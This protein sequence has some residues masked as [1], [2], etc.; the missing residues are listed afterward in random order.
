MR[1]CKQCVHARRACD[2]KE[3]KCS[4]KGKSGRGDAIACCAFKLSAR[5]FLESVSRADKRLEDMS[6]RAQHYREIAYRATGSMEA[7]RVSGTAGR[8]KVESNINRCLDIA[9][10]IDRKAE[11][12]RGKLAQA[13][14]MIDSVSDP[15]GQEVLELRY[16]HRMRW[17]EIAKRMNYTQR[18][19]VHIHGAA[20]REAQMKMDQNN[21]NTY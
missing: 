15:Q 1:Y 13:Q 11:A 21:K 9:R 2:R 5:A 20:L 6:W 10:D 3:I 4:L 19:V 12:L 18:N 16:L 17:E 14:E 8:S 7:T